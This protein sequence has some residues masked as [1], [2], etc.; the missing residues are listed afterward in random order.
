MRSRSAKIWPGSPTVSM[1][2]CELASR[3]SSSWSARVWSSSERAEIARHS[4]R[5]APLSMRET[6][7]RSRSRRSA[8]CPAPDSRDVPLALGVADVGVERVAGEDDRVERAAQVVGDDREQLVARRRGG[9]G[10]GE[11]PRGLGVGL[12]EPHREAD[13]AGQPGRPEVLGGQEIGH[14][15]RVGGALDLVVGL[16][17][18]QQH[19]DGPAAAAQRRDQIER[20]GAE[21]MVDD[22]AVVLGIGLPCLTGPRER[23]V[24]IRLLV[25]GTG[26]GPLERPGEG[27]P[28]LAVGG[29]QE[30]P[31]DG[32]RLRRGRHTLRKV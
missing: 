1:R 16:R 30:D 20:G 21:A 10:A 27:G 7:S 24:E 25:D 19:R 6:S 12:A 9:L 26:P 31:R 4:S 15:R 23:A 28:L 8:R 22:H 5:S 11:H 18:V 29:D 3:A 14:A 13:P 32:L 2:I 17:A